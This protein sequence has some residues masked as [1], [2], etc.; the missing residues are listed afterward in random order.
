MLLEKK[1]VCI[2]KQYTAAHCQG[3]IPCSV[4]F[5]TVYKCSLSRKTRFVC[6]LFLLSVTCTCTLIST[7]NNFLTVAYKCS[8]PQK[9][10]SSVQF[11][12]QNMDWQ[13]LSSE[14]SEPLEEIIRD[15][16]Y[17]YRE[18]IRVTHFKINKNIFLYFFQMLFG[19][20]IYFTW[21]WE[22]FIYIYWVA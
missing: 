20:M 3:K 4:Y 8:L 19:W 9:V 7:S 12:L 21:T 16:F 5:F 2:I 17:G 22:I 18:A 1:V 14:L 11:G 15:N 13:N 6:A 10:S